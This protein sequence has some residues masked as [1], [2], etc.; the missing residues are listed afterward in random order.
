MSQR[1]NDEPRVAMLIDADNVSGRN[2]AAVIA[3]AGRHG[4]PVIRRIYGDW[5]STALRQWKA[6]LADHAVQPIQQFA[7]STG[8]NAT[9][10]ALIIDAMDL[11]HADA[12]EVFCIVSSD[13]DFTRLASRLRESAREVVGIGR[14][15]TPKA[16]VQAC[17]RFIF[18]E[19]LIDSDADAP[20][21]SRGRR[22]A[23]A[24]VDASAADDPGSQAAEVAPLGPLLERAYDDAETDDGYAL[25]G[26]IGNALQRIDPAFDPRNYGFRQLRRLVEAQPDLSVTKHPD[27]NALIVTRAGS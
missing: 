10:S 2:A 7:N 4:R 3:E 27:K 16:F 13:A 15:K 19:N 11:L 26:A 20:A 14:R 24:N 12:A 1:M 9:D 18:I 5:T 6:I 17:D 25:L 21:P 8:K 23:D 22:N